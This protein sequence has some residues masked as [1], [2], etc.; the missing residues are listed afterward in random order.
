M[1]L[2][3][4]YALQIPGNVTMFTIPVAARSRSHTNVTG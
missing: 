4:S 1:A 3:G 2:D